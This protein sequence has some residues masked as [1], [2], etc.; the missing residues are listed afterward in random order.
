MTTLSRRYDGENRRPEHNEQRLT[1]YPKHDLE[2]GTGERELL[3]GKPNLVPD[4]VHVVVAELIYNLFTKPHHHSH[5]HPR[6]T[7]Y[8]PPQKR[9]ARHRNFWVNLLNN[10]RHWWKTSRLLVRLSGAY[11]WIMIPANW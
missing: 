5:N 2:F 4:K 10:F 3:I 11:G 7:P 8:L 1:L 9:Y 6:S